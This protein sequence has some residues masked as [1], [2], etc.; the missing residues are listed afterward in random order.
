MIWLAS[1]AALQGNV[2]DQLARAA[3]NWAKSLAWVT[4]SIAARSGEG[5]APA[6]ST[7]TVWPAWVM[8]GPCTV[9]RTVR[10]AGDP[11]RTGIV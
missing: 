1:F 6:Q 5:T 3:R 9:I 8:I 11:P 4:P 2:T 10:L 7:D